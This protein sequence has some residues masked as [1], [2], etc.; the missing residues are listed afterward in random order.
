MRFALIALVLL[1]VATTAVATHAQPRSTPT[2]IGPR[3]PGG[4]T[5]PMGKSYGGGGGGGGNSIVSDAFEHRLARLPSLSG[6]FPNGNVGVPS[7]AT[8]P[9][10]CPNDDNWSFYGVRGPIPVLSFND[11]YE[12]IR[13][14]VEALKKDI[15]REREIEKAVR[16]LAEGWLLDYSLSQTV[17]KYAR[18]KIKEMAEDH[19]KAALITMLQEAAKARRND[20]GQLTPYFWDLRPSSREKRE[21]LNSVADDVERAEKSGASDI[22]LRATKTF[23]SPPSRGHVLYKP[24]PA[25]QQLKQIERE[26]RWKNQ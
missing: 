11:R 17:D 4:P 6:S 8:C 10:R 21:V 14:I 16:I 7:G 9:P 18:L 20:I 25:M 1:Q 22:Y 15:D 23:E 26:R 2:D 5:G 24:G 19:L 12:A 13:Q 3:G